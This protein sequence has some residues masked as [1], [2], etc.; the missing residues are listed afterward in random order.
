MSEERNR[1]V[2]TRLIPAGVEQVYEAW[3]NPTLMK[4]W[5]CPG[6]DMSVPIAESDP[7][8]GGR[9]RVQMLGP[10]GDTHTTS[11]V[12]QEVVPN[13]RLRFTWQWE[14]SE[15]E[16]EVTI[17][18]RA[19]SNRETELTL[20]HEGFDT[21]EARDKHRQGWTGCLSK[22]VAGTAFESAA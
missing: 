8:E 17:E 14:G 3:T 5:F 15:V 1:L 11:G 22:L 21:E 10:D 12:F 2:L 4:R 6:D 19:L 7:R 13:E 20:V 18:L 9:Y 16:T